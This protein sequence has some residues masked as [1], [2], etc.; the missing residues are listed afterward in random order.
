MSPT[1]LLLLT[2]DASVSNRTTT[3]ETHKTTDTLSS[4]GTWLTV[5][6]VY[7]WHKKDIKSHQGSSKNFCRLY[8]LQWAIEK[9]NLQLTLNYLNIY[10]R[11]Y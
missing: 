7:Y 5:A 10:T 8:V 9:K 2:S 3:F 6:V 4:I 1:C 11:F